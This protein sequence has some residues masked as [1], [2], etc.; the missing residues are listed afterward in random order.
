MFLYVQKRP[1][2]RHRVSGNRKG[3]LAGYWRTWIE[4]L[5]R[6]DSINRMIQFDQAP[7]LGL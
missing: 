3:R 2:A 7:I 5:E 4:E 6:L 1:L